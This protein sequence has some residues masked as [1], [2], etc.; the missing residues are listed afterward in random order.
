LIKSALTNI[1]KYDNSK[2]IKIRFSI[3]FIQWTSLTPVNYINS[4]LLNVVLI[5][6]SNFSAMKYCSL[7]SNDK[8]DSWLGT[9]FLP[10][11]LRNVFNISLASFSNFLNGS[12]EDY[13][14]INR[15]IRVILVK[16]FNILLH[17]LCWFS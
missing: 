10:V 16:A 14:M 17:F 8:L 4:N 13:L 2:I 9:R 12:K 11:V 1:L 7:F 3:I 15:Y 6:F 5:K